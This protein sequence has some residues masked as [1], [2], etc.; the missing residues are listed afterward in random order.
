MWH[1]KKILVYHLA[2]LFG[3]W[4]R[5]G[6]SLVAVSRLCF[7]GGGLGDGWFSIE[8][9]CFLW[10]AQRLWLNCWKIRNSKLK[11]KSTLRKSREAP[12]AMAFL[13]VSTTP[14]PVMNA[15]RG[16]EKGKLSHY[17]HRCHRG[18]SLV[19]PNSRGLYTH[20]EDSLFWKVG[21]PISPS[22][23]TFSG[24]YDVS[25]QSL[26]PCVIRLNLD[27]PWPR[28]YG[29]IS[30]AVCEKVL[31]SIDYLIY[32]STSTFKGVPNGS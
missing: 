26:N 13:H 6:L 9:L 10:V 15:R 24:T 1:G 14:W 3:S 32:I 20:Y 7:G 12:R 25:L 23:A 21:W 29:R 2:L 19:N 16:T 30:W 4:V 31:K 5:R 8:G 22:N 27:G 18:W 11:S 17:F 28:R